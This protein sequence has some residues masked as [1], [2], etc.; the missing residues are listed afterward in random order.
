M[1]PLLVAACVAAGLAAA[2][3]R[4]AQACRGPADRNC[5]IWRDDQARK[6]EVARFRKLDKDHDGHLSR[7]EAA[8]SRRLATRFVKL[9]RNDDGRLSFAEIP[10][11]LWR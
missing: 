4:P 10:R 6:A 1:S 7:D 2:A 9:D 8:V 11:R 5:V 3:A